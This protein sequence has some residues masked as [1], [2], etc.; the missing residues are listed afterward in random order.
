MKKYF[1]ISGLFVALLTSC[2]DDVLNIDPRDKYVEDRFF[3]SKEQAEAAVNGIYTALRHTGVYGGVAPLYTRETWSPN[4]YAYNG[5]QNLVIQGNHDA[6]TGLFNNAWN[7]VYLGIGRANNL[8]AR[9]DP[10]PMDDNLKKRFKAEAKFLRAVF[11]MPLWNYFGGAPLILATPDYTTQSNLPRNTPSELLVQILKDLDEAITDLPVSYSGTDKGRATKGAALAF[12]ARVL[13][14]AGRYAEAAVAAKAV[15]DSKIYSLFP[16]YRGLFYLENEGNVEVIFDIQYKYPE[17][18]HDMDIS[19][20]QFNTVAPTPDLV[21]DY[22]MKDDGLPISISTLYKPAQPYSG[23]DPRLAA[24]VILPGSTYKGKPV[25]ATQYPRTGYG[26]KKYSI[27]KDTE[28]PVQ[29]LA[30]GLSE[31]NYIL[32]RYADILL[33]YAEAQNEI[34]GPDPSVYDAIKQVRGRT[35]VQMPV[36]PANLSQAKMREEIRHERRIELAGEGLYYDDIR[37]WKTAG[38]VLNVDAVNIKGERIDTRRFDVNRD[39]LWPVPSI[40]IQENP[41]LTQN[42]KYGK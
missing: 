13:L 19:L 38:Q 18:G 1:L 21:N 42:P 39:Y 24:T 29:T 3:Q 31:L 40:A 36:L 12:K 5:E 7:G 11:Y 20:D 28:V 41:A 10:I 32:L 23:R 37:R 9:I 33:M 27:Y 30:A 22:Y 2:K 35:S 16:D 15:I 6:N 17:S 34:V 4:A 8:L 14:Y 26:Q 25:T